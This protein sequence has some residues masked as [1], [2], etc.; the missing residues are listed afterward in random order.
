MPD[1]YALNTPTLAGIPCLMLAPADAPA[2]PPTAIV[3]HG[4]G[5]HKEATLPILY[6]FARHGLRAVAPDAR[7]HGVRPGEADRDGRLDADYFGTMAEIIEG[8]SQDVSLLLDALGMAQAAIHG[9]SLGGYVA[10]AAMADDPRLSIGAVAM[11]SPDWL[12][13]LRDAGLGPGHPVYDAV[14]AR[15]PLERA[16]VFPPRPLLMLHGDQDTTVSI[17]GVWAMQAAL[18]PLYQAAPDHLKLIVYPGLDHIYT[19]DMMECAAD[20]A[21]RHLG[22]DSG[23]APWV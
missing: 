8:T 10:F 1:A 18:E 21:A 3:L 17:R 4:L 13:P 6:A 15:S 5:R 22:A 11:G 2:D 23:G 19:D 9:V 14:A 12:E 7:L 16:A 20:W